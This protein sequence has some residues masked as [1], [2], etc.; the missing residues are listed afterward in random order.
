MGKR[1]CLVHYSSAPGGIEVLMPEIIRMLPEAEF[2]IFVIRPPENEKNNVYDGSATDITY[3]SL[4]NFR[5]AF[6][7]WRFGRR[8]RN[9]VFHGFN[10][11]PFFLFVLRLAGVRRVVY[12]VRGTKHYSTPYQKFLRRGIWNLAITKHSRFIANSVYSRDVFTGYLP[13]VKSQIRV[14]YNPVFSDRIRVTDGTGAT[15]G[16]NIIYV[17]RLIEGKNLFRWINIATEIRKVRKDARFNL[18]GDGPLRERLIEYSRAA[19]MDDCL[20]FRGYVKDLSD[21]Y[22]GADLMLFLSEYESFGNAV[23]ESILYGTPVLAADIPS[24]REIFINH[25]VFILRDGDQTAD[26]ILNRIDNPEKIQRATREA[27]RE[28]RQKFSMDQH[29]DGLREVYATF[30]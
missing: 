26:A 12:S 10:T 3:G 29:I 22:A 9:A 7:L 4:N 25:P 8:N 21:I 18:F 14:I 27:D 19:A 28:F 20:I 23:V 11:G 15:V 1:I 6:R 5:A 24:I 17:G 2:L 16:M 13:R 30:G